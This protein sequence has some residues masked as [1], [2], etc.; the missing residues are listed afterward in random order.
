MSVSGLGTKLWDPAE[1][2]VPDL[3]G[4]AEGWAAFLEAGY[5]PWLEHSPLKVVKRTLPELLGCHRLGVGGRVASSPGQQ[6][7]QPDCLPPFVV[8]CPENVSISGYSS[9]AA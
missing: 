8:R 9:S 4:G 5:P 2:F 6:P 7:P 1:A 3:G